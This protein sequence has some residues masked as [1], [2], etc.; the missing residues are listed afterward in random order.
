MT[1]TVIG[2][3]VNSA[4]RLEG[5]TRIYKVPVICSDFVKEDIEKNVTN[6][7]IRFIEIDQVQVKGKTVGKR[8]YWPLWK[9]I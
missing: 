3:N 9:K 1:N 7:G 2:D 8:V 4:S 5:L 6:H